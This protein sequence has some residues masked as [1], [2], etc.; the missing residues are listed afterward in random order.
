[1]AGLA[2]AAMAAFMFSPAAGAQRRP[3]SP[4]YGTS[5]PDS[6][7]FMAVAPENDKMFYMLNLMKYR[8]K[9][10]YG[11]GPEN[12]L[13]GREAGQRYNPQPEIQKVGGYLVYAGDV[14]VQL[15]GK[16]P[17][18]DTV[19]MVMYPSRAKFREMTSSAEFRDTVQHKRASL[20]ITQVIVTT[21][22][23]WTFSDKTPLAAKDIPY[24]ATAQDQSFTFLHLVKYRDVAQY[25]AGSNEP[26]RSG[27]EAMELFEKSAEEI[28]HQAGVVPMMRAEVDGVLVGDGRTWSDYRLLR[29]PSHRA[30][31][32]V[33]E[34]I[35]ESDFGHHHGAALEDE[36]TFEL[37]TRIDQTDSLR[38]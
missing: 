11:D 4:S 22:E 26:K 32:E 6:A 16:D 10:D 33:V 28:L 18:W 30:W 9:A 36:Y 25:P 27:R 12:G 8:D 21:P 7:S 5:N 1:M 38:K 37:K 34:K 23:P 20:G 14:E 35:G 17:T 15:E 13:S 2:I 19:A 24:P 3:G 29:V 31:E